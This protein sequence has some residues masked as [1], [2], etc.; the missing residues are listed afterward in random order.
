MSWPRE[1]VGMENAVYIVAAM[2]TPIAKL[3]GAFVG[4]GQMTADILACH[5]SRK[6]LDC[7]FRA[8]VKLIRGG[9]WMGFAFPAADRRPPPL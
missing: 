6:K 5:H 2:R 3:N 1:V 8:G 9:A 7:A 4:L